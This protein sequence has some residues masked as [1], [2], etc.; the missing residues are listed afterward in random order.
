MVDICRL[1]E[2]K[3]TK[4]NTNLK[5]NFIKIKSGNLHQLNQLRI[6]SHDVSH[7]PIYSN[8]KLPHSVCCRFAN[9]K[10]IHV[11]FWAS[12]FGCSDH[13]SRLKQTYNYLKLLF[14]VWTD[15]FMILH[16]KYAVSKYNYCDKFEIIWV[17]T[18]VVTLFI[19]S[20]VNSS[21]LRLFEVEIGE[22]YCFQSI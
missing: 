19:Y 9:V 15:I 11:I 22:W 10:F 1:E 17:Y 12:Y 3:T 21:S 16:F 8:K 4:L 5:L 13:K 18:F 2:K 7:K 20:Y 14:F 6:W